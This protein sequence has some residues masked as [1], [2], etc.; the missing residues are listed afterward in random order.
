D[1]ELARLHAAIRL[2]LP[3]LPA[4]AASSPYVEGRATPEL[5]HRLL[6]YRENAARV[7]SVSGMVVPE[8]IVS[9]MDYQQRVLQPIYDDLAPLD[10]EGLL[11]HEWVNARGCIARFDRGALEVRVL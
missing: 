5:D 1:D 8:H 3:L 6:V 4:L 10:P 7:P 9:A 2:L 11:R